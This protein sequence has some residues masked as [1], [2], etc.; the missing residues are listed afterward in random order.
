MGDNAECQWYA[1]MHVRE[2]RGKNGAHNNAK[3]KSQPGVCSIQD[4]VCLVPNDFL[5]K[6]V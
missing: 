6:I 3:E 4:T 5:P 1:Q 2:E